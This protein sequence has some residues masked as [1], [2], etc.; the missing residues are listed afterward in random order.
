MDKIIKNLYSY[1]LIIFIIFPI[2]LQADEIYLSNGQKAE[3][4]ILDTSG[5]SVKINRKG[6]EVTI[7]KK[8]ITKIVW[9]SD[10]IDYSDYECQEKPKIKATKYQDTPEYKLKD[11]LEKCPEIEQVFNQNSK[12][13][14]LVTP[15][16]G[17]FNTDEFIV[18][19]KKV[20]ET[21]KIK[22]KIKP[23]TA[24]EL[25]SEIHNKNT[26]FDYGFIT[27]EY[28][29]SNL[30]K[31]PNKP[32]KNIL[33]TNADFIL[34]DLKRKEIVFHRSLFEKR[35]ITVGG[36][37]YLYFFTPI[38]ATIVNSFIDLEEVIEEEDKRRI[39]KKIDRNAQRIIKKIVEETK[40][41]LEIPE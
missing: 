13:A 38:T 19:Q 24:T 21:F 10:T 22:S 40:K 1:C 5:F 31:D 17:R 36:D 4:T 30:K 20:M 29:V 6:K 35:S 23:M 28:H 26:H 9:N 15:L 27:K 11:I 34:F 37:D 3:T 41:Y 25:L 8:L 12:V 14:F 33:L 16:Q 39:E 18:V 2:Y 7:K 32:N